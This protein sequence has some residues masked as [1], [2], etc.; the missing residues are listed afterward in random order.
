MTKAL[1]QCAFVAALFALHPLHVESVA[2]VAERKDVLS[3]FSWMLTMGA[4]VYYVEHPRPLRYVITLIFFALGLMAKPMLVT[5]PFVLLLL[6]YWP[7]KRFS[8]HKS[9]QRL[10]NLRLPQRKNKNLKS[11]LPQRKKCRQKTPVIPFM[12]GHRFAL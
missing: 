2:W 11:N 5:L 3:T 7:L 6:D 8:F 1:W 4:Y 12:N 9:M 10:L